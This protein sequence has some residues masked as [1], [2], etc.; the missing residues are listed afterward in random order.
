MAFKVISENNAD[1]DENFINPNCTDH[2]GVVKDII[3]IYFGH[4][5]GKSCD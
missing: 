3:F 4:N 1:Y 2:S 5:Y